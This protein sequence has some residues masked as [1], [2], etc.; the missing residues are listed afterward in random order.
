M[1]PGSVLKGRGEGEG[2]GGD[3]RGGEISGGGTV[4]YSNDSI[5]YD[6]AEQ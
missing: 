5:P 4:V 2:K 1:D 3:V 6:T